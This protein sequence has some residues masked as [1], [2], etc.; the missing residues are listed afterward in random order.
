MNFTCG[1]Q[2][3]T[4][5]AGLMVELKRFS[6]I[7]KEGIIVAQFALWQAGCVAGSKSAP[8]E[9]FEVRSHPP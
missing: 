1:S 4:S 2:N 9:Q 8:A 7:E 5:R 3:L 6:L